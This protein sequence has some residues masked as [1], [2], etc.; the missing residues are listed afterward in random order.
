MIRHVC[1]LLFGLCLGISNVS[2]SFERAMISSTSKMLEHKVYG[3]W[4]TKESESSPNNLPVR[5]S[6]KIIQAKDI[7]DLKDYIRDTKFSGVVYLSDENNV[8]R[9]ASEKFELVQENKL[10]FAIHSIGKV[11]TGML[12]LIMLQDGIIDESVLFS[13]LEIG[14]GA[15]QCLP[16]SVQ[17]HLH[18]TTL[19]KTMVHKGGF[20]DYLG[21]YVAAV[22]R[23]LDAE[24]HP[25]I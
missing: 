8:Y 23:D 20:S 12:A 7:Q 16:L 11:Y 17:Q 4:Y 3:H 5:K 22:R 9:I 19:Y 18:K 25:H 14:S 15:T 1:F 13:P 21:K 2:F 10:I 24:Q 6:K